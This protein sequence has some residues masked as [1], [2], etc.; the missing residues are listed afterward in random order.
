VLK[1]APTEELQDAQSLVEAALR[2]LSC[3][4][5]TGVGGTNK[6]DC[7]AAPPSPQP[8]SKRQQPIGGGNM[9]AATN[10]DDAVDDSS[11]GPT[12]TIA[13]VNSPMTLN[14]ARVLQTPDPNIAS[15]P[16][17]KKQFLT[18]TTPNFPLAQLEETS[19]LISTTTT[20][21]TATNDTSPTAAMHGSNSNFHNNNNNADQFSTLVVA[22]QE[23]RTDMAKN[24]QDP[25]TTVQ[26]I[27]G[28]EE[29]AGTAEQT[30]AMWK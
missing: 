5:T 12:T 26:P 24:G 4:S 11:I 29:S 10:N 15:P 9:A 18:M 2:C 7:G 3:A 20:T 22:S 25:M 16:A 17:T 27:T 14:Y 28:S 8:S 13:A 23:P 19:P 1:A 30:N 6:N 21:T